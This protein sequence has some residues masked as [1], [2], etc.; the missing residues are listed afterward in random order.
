MSSVIPSALSIIPKPS[1]LVAQG[2]VFHV[3]PQTV[4]VAD[5]AAWGEARRLADWISRAAGV[6]CPVIEPGEVSTDTPTVVLQIDPKA[7]VRE[8][9]SYTLSVTPKRVTL[10]AAALP[11]LFYATQTL[12]QLLPVSFESQSGTAS[13]EC[14]IPCLEIE[15]TPRFTWRGAM[16]DVARHFLP[17][18]AVLKF[19]DLLAL[20]KMNVLHLHLTD[21]QGWRMEIKKYPRLT[22]VGAFRE[23]TLVG[24][25]L[26]NPGHA[27]FDPLAERFDDVPY[28]GFYTQDELREIVAYAAA[29]H[30]TVIPEIETPGH[31]QAAVAAYPDLGCGGEP[32]EVSPRWGIH[33][34]LFAPT[35]HTFRFLEDVLAEV[36]DVFPSPYI[37]IGGDEAVKTRW[38]K[39]A[40]CQALMREKAL[41]NAEE[42]QSY[43][44]GRLDKFLTAHGR[45]LVGWDEILEGGL[46][47]GAVVMSWR[48]EEGGVEAAGQGHDVVM[49]PHRFTYLDYYQAEEHAAEPLAFRETLPLSTVYDYEPVPAALSPE[50]ARHVLG[51]QGQ[52]WSEYMPNYRQ[53]EYQAFPRLCALAEVAWTPREHKNYAG[54][55]DRLAPHLKRLEVLGVNARPIRPRSEGEQP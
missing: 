35:T 2:G 36:L 14:V 30:V 11:G 1:H 55:L 5:R 42:L 40:E 6:S 41:T 51:T 29:R 46:S 43:F 34:V 23:R 8:R 37:H 10:R 44:I 32:G 17:V 9:E 52:L 7:S 49:A 16:L 15:D 54:F 28:G 38:Q 19:I 33:D 47:P 22:S 12:R 27:D 20:H 50:A 24:T 13:S 21:D 26:T 53:V 18:E 45:T 4:I 3:T 25:A 39:S 48:G 31:A